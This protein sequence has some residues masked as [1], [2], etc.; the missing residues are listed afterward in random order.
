VE[1]DEKKGKIRESGGRGREESKSV[2][3]AI[4][5]YQ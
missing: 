4:T 1:I 2:T 5:K 3:L